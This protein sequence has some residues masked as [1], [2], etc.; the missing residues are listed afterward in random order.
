MY[1]RVKFLF[2]W[3]FRLLV[4]VLVLS[5][6][7]ILLKDILLKELLQN[8]FRTATGL[9]ARI[10]R[11]EVSLF[12]P[13][14]TIENLRL[15]NPPEFGGL[16]LLIAPELHAEYDRPRLRDRKLRLNLLRLNISEL[17][18]V[19]NASG[20]GNLEAILAGLNQ[21]LATGGQAFFS[22]DGIQALNLTVGELK[23]VRLGPPN[24]VQTFPAGIK[25]EV[26]T[27][28]MTP[29]D[30]ALT[31]ARLAVRLGLHVAV[32]PSPRAPSP[33]STVPPQFTPAPPPRP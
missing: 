11:L 7:L 4:L 12:S 29:R 17:T 8:R 1:L 24:A 2:R 32:P 13:T 6:G 22:F 15:F 28:L 3:A 14:V 9:E 25:N 20:R 27:G 16:P 26:I 33:G 10:G 21:R 19:Q 30:L 31:L 18:M 23:R 5:V